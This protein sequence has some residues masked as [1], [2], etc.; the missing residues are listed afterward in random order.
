V[1]RNACRVH[2]DLLSWSFDPRL[3]PN[4]RQGVTR[5]RNRIAI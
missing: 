2:D 3:R 5:R 1:A 4:N